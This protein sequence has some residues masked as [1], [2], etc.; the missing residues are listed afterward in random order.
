MA[1]DLK[2]GAAELSLSVANGVERISGDNNEELTVATVKVDPVTGGIRYLLNGPAISGEWVTT[3][4]VFKVVITGT[5]SVTMD[6]RDA[7]GD[8]T[9]SVYSESLS[10]AVNQVG[11]PYA[12]DAAMAVRFNFP[13]TISVQVI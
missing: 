7:N 13:S 9:S 4:A 11:F 5:G 2:I 1:L 12:G 10:G 8:I 3:A 6:A